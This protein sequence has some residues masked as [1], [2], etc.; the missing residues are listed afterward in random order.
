M[1]A[2]NLEQDNRPT[3]IYTLHDPRDGRVRYV[4]KTQQT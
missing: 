2:S 4:G 3:Y 1:T